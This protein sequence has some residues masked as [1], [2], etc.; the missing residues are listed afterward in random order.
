MAGFTVPMTRREAWTVPL[1]RC[2]RS[3]R[4]PLSRTGEHCDIDSADINDGRDTV[5]AC[6]HPD[7]T[8]VAGAQPRLRGT[9]ET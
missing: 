3:S 4:S 2:R 5:N 9:M 1:S 7:A 6:G 8:N